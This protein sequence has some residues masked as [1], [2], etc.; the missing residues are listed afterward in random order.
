MRHSRHLLL[1]FALLFSAVLFCVSGT[2][3]AQ[4]LLD[5]LGQGGV[6]GSL[7]EL[8]LT[9]T[10]TADA[11]KPGSTATLALEVQLPP[12]FYIYS[13]SPSFGGGTRLKI[14]EATGLEPMDDEFQADRAPKVVEDE[15]LM[16]TVEKFHDRV[17]W[18]RRFRIADDANLDAVRV[19][20]TI[21][22][23][24][25]SEDPENGKCIPIRP[26]REFSAALEQ[27]SP[28]PPVLA[29]L[30]GS[31][32]RA[33]GSAATGSAPGT[34]AMQVTPERLAGKKEPL[35]LS[36]RLEPTDATAGE[37]VTLTITARL[38]DK[39]HI[40]ALDQD[41]EMAGLPTEIEV[42]VE[43]LEAT[44]AFQP[45]EPPETEEPLEDIV[46]RV[47]YGEISWTRPYHVTDGT[48]AG[49]YKATGSINYQVCN[50]G[51]CRP[52][53][54]VEFA[55]GMGTGTPTGTRTSDEGTRSG[56]S[57]PPVASSNTDSDSA[58]GNSDADSASE[59]ATA[60][61]GQ[62]TEGL[63]PSKQGLVAFLLTAVV[64]GFAALL[65]PCVFPMVP[66]T[67][68]LF[69]KQSEQ[70][71]HRP[72]WMATIYCVGIVISFTV[73]GLLMAALF[74][75]TSINKL[76]NNPWLN[77]GIAGVLIFFGMNLL[78]MFEIRIPSFL[79]SWSS[80][81]ES[82]GGVMGVLFMALTFTLVS[83]T[84][85]F[86]FAG[87][88]L[89]MASRGQVYWPVLGML[90]FSSAFAL[91][92]FFLALF[93]STLKKLPKSG[94]WMNTVKVTMGMI[95]IG[96]ALKFLSV[97]DWAWNPRPILFDY[98]FVMASWMILL[99][100]MGLYLLGAFRL[101]HDTAEPNISVVRFSFAMLSLTFGGYLGVGLFGAEKP[102]GLVWEQIE[103]FAPAVISGGQEQE[104]GPFL[105]HDGLKYAL[106][107]D[108]AR[109]Y[110]QAQNQP[111]FLDFTGVN[112]V[113]CRLM[114]RRMKKPEYRERLEKF[115]RVQLY[116]DN[117]PTIKD[118]AEVERLLQQ[119]RKL[120]EEWFRDVTLPSYAVVSPDGSTVLATMKGLESEQ[121]MFADF[122]DSG[123][124]AWQER[125][126]GGA[127]TARVESTTRR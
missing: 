73:L 105:E 5:A 64:F 101:S 115:V 43:G 13:T 56:E 61:A 17:V 20:G 89:V 116:T 25:C 125:T 16:Q 84:C 44:G 10:L 102:S 71:H 6:G 27:G 49:A 120:Q 36:F 74:G 30:D 110:A 11:L 55:V 79:L 87:G 126:S 127:P 45:S 4:G 119:N 98:A 99:F 32:G 80:G 7:E 38:E 35:E 26:P 39:W 42:Q 41:P 34:Y 124:Q 47:H 19:A 22:G 97:A 59:G 106:D 23:Q 69:L 75:A 85:T 104:L 88:L 62:Q 63:D 109:E 12:D 83:F 117:V 86:A 3:Q 107:Y 53:F 82:Q 60:T 113:N 121:G 8:E 122:L 66:I 112:C 94:G 111:M 108:Q 100:C 81:K 118:E 9:A 52:P 114:E 95:E 50:A 72:V 67:V 93:P 78:G 90:A 40:F 2:V 1:R 92:F 68:S 65:T 123:L 33:D 18:F 103:A 54:T 21:E 31:G 29:A 70:E 58:T 48:A 14:T 28:P 76:A 46:Q 91:P 15:L 57:G 51:V 77:L 96:A 24:Y 37:N